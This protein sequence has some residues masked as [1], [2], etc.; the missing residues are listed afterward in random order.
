MKKVLLIL[1]PLAFLA[2]CSS[3]RDKEIS[4]ISA[5]EKEVESAGARP[6]LARL[7]Q[8]LD[9]YT[10]FADKYSSD[11]LAPVYMFKA[12]NLCIGVNNGHRAMQLI[13]T[14]L[15][16]FPESRYNAETV[17]LKAFVYENLLNNYGQASQV[18]NY[19]L[20]KYPNHEL[21]DDADAAL[22][23]M[24][25]SPEELVEEF[26]AARKAQAENAKP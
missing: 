17:F 21:A 4:S 11:T 5:L 15:N 23:N 19:F 20:K 10:L 13:D 24:G 12:I 25:K 26:E 18:Y 6:E 2:A 7:E 22:K 8:L 14:A 1:L 16:K 3:P 9:A